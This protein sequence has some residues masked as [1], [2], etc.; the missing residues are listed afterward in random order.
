[1]A[2]RHALI[3]VAPLCLGPVR[4]VFYHFNSNEWAICAFPNVTLLRNTSP[5]SIHSVSRPLDYDFMTR[6]VHAWNQLFAA[7]LALH[8]PST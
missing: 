3:R 7:N 4:A 1:M 6:A 5:S 8:E 2:T